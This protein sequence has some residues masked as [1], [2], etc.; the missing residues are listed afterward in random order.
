MINAVRGRVQQS[1]YN[2]ERTRGFMNSAVFTKFQANVQNAQMFLDTK[3]LY[4]VG[5]QGFRVNN[6]EFY[7]DSYCPGTGTAASADNYIYII[8]MDI[9]K[10]FYKFGF[11]SASPFDT[12]EMRIPDQPILSTQKFIAGNWVCTDRRLIAV[13]KTITL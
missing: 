12:D 9:F 7:L 1:E 4:S 10:F 13:C 2:P 11:D 5:F 8:P 3:D 6:V